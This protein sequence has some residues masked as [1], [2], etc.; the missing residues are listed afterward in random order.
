MSI[1]SPLHKFN[2]DEFLRMAEIGL[3]DGQ[4]RVE[5]IDGN[6]RELHPDSMETVCNIGNATQLHKFNSDEFLRMAEIGLFDEQP[7]VELIDGIVREMSPINPPHAFTVH[8]IYAK[9]TELLSPAEMVWI[10]NPISLGAFNTPEPDIA[11]LRSSALQKRDKLP[12]AADVI[13]IIEVSDSS[14]EFDLVTKK[15]QYAEAGIAEYWVV[16]IPHQQIIQFLDPKSS[17]YQSQNTFSPGQTIT[18]AALPQLQ[19]P[20]AILIP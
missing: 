16:D 18:S 6:V 12:T 9:C 17:D 13:L 15:R 7:R 5:L 1:A 14:L 8:S 19:F 3:F 20:V 4:P 11:I 10:Q 2:S